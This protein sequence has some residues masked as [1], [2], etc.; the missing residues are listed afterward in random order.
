MF[1][2]AQGDDVQKLLY[3][4]DQIEYSENS[5][6]RS[7]FRVHLNKYFQVNTLFFS[8]FKNG[9]EKKDDGQIL[10]S[11]K[12][13]PNLFEKLAQKGVDIGS[14]DYLIVRN[15]ID[16]L[17]KVIK[18]KDKYS[19]KVGFRLS[20]PKRAAKYETKEA[21][22]K[23][24][25]LSLINHK[26]TSYNETG[27]IN[28]CDIFLPT[29]T[30]MKND[31]FQ[32]VKTDIF[33]IPSAV[34]PANIKQKTLNLDEKIRF[35]YIGTFDKLR[36]F[37]TVLKA[38]EKLEY[39][40]YILTIATKE[41]AYLEHLLEKFPSLKEKIQICVIKT[42]QEYQDLVMSSDVGISLLPNV[43]LFNSSIPIKVFEF[44]SWGTPCIISDI[45]INSAVFD[46][47]INAWLSKFDQESIANKLSYI[48]TLSKEEIHQVAIK[49]QEK[50]LKVRNYEIIA[51][52]LA[53][54]L[55]S[56]PS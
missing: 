53:Q 47:N 50:L 52:N 3:I 31:Y 38:F 51:S 33:E 2:L 30:Q 10:V 5:F 39:E 9:I 27:L 16:I 7:L 49:G 37:S 56:L 21:N 19:F 40:N 12:L 4:T 46:D 6:I 11:E 15:D 1:N 35:F 26:I 29:S 48:T 13:R 18:L 41:K 25:L 55:K 32:D 23:S 44:Y 42:N 20:F 22:N 45:S 17:K 36:E 34:D 8:K 28:K 14:Y 54:E 24:S 43:K